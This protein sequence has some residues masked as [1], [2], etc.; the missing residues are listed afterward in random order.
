[1]PPPETPIA[2]ADTQT[3]WL[4]RRLPPRGQA[5]AQLARYDRPIGAWLLFWPCFWGMALAAA[6]LKTLPPFLSVMAFALGALAM[7]GAGCTYN[8]IIDRELDAQ[9][10]RTAVGHSAEK[11]RPKWIDLQHMLPVTSPRTWWLPAPVMRLWFSLLM[12]LVL[13]SRLVF[14][15]TRTVLAAWT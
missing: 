4:L 12:P 13:P 1:M 5:I 2:P 7:R 11:T 15:S 9:V 10:A 6:E 3:N 14:M 8:D